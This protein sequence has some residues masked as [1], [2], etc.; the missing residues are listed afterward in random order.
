M[1]FRSTPKGN[2]INL[3]QGA[4]PIDF[5]YAIHSAV[6]NRMIGA[7]VNGRIVPIDYTL[8]N[9]EIVDVITSKTTGGPKRDWLKMVKT[10]EARNK[11]KQWFK[12]ECR[13][14]N[15]ERGKLDLERELRSALLLDYFNTDE[16]RAAVL[17]RLSFAAADELYAS[18]GYGGI[19][20]EER[21][22][23]KE[24]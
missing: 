21:R 11:I 24:C 15:I 14:E 7:K 8:K 9:G 19:R 22:V 16:I 10:A 17:K 6:G 13:E 20:S 2:V 23:G 12:K 5:A 4:N 1:L 3:P 18:L